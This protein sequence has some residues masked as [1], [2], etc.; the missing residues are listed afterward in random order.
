MIKAEYA[1]D[2]PVAPVEA[3]AQLSD[4]V[5]EPEWSS[6]CVHTRLLNGQPRPGCQYEITFE[7]I[8][9]RMSFTVEID[10]FEPGHRSRLHTL[11]GP[12]HYAG[13]YAYTER[14]DGTTGVRWTFE[15][16]AGDYFGIMPQS[17]LKKV[18][19]SQIK[20]DSGKLADRL[21][22]AALSQP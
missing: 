9:K 20:K 7:M 2:L 3:F 14:A 18:L 17:L 21:A 4:P 19:E 13:T 6:S 15:V 12:F 22:G 11:E 16:E 1:F 5:R 8:G 10:E